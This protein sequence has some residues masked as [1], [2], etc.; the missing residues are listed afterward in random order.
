MLT[1]ILQ[2][3][4][5]T[6]SFLSVGKVVPISPARFVG[7]RV[8]LVLV[9]LVG[10]VLVGVLVLVLHG[11][12]RVVQFGDVERWRVG[13]TTAATQQPGQ[14]VG[15]RLTQPGQT[16]APAEPGQRLARRTQ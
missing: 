9:V 2:D 10:V 1:S 5:G 11:V 14:R 4:S 13:Q 15:E 3:P 7:V 6:G 12:G 16:S 8:G